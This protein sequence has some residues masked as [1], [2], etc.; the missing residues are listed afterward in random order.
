M[1]ITR[2]QYT[3]DFYIGGGTS[4][5]FSVTV[6]A[7]ASILVVLSHNQ[8]ARS[9]TSVTANGQAMTEVVVFTAVCTVYYTFTFSCFPQ[10]P[11]IEGHCWCRGA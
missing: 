1:V 2:D 10:Q 11:A 8:N 3:K 4:Q 5:T 6:A 7:T 9:Y